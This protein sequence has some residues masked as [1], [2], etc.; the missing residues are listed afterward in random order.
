MKSEHNVLSS[1]SMYIRDGYN[2]VPIVPKQ[3]RPRKKNWPEL[4]IK[5]SEIPEHFNESDNIGIVLGH[6]LVDIDLDCKEAISIASRY[7]PKTERVHG[8]KSKPASHFWFRT[9]PTMK[10]EKFSDP[11]D[12][13]SL[14]E[15]RSS[16]GQQTV[17]P[18]SI[19]KSGERIRWKKEGDPSLVA[20]GKLRTAA[21]RIAAVALIAKRW[22]EQS[23]NNIVL[24]LSGAL[25]HAGWKREKVIKLVE[26]IAFAAKDE[27][28]E[29]RVAAV[30]ATWKKLKAGKPVTGTPSLVVELGE[31]TV[32]SL[33]SW[34][35]IG[36]DKSV[37]Q[38]TKSDWR[39]V[40]HSVED[41]ENAPPTSFSIEGFL[42]DYV[43]TVVAGLS[44]DG[45]TLILHSIMKALLSRH[46]H[47]KLWNHFKVL[48]I[49]PRVLYLTPESAITPVMDRLRRF[50]LYRYVKN[51]QLLVRTLSKGPTPKLSD[52]KIL[53]A[54]KG[55]HV[56]LDPTVRFEEGDEN[57]AFDNQRLANAIF[58]LL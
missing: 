26:A 24:P 51:G 28:S 30:E 56:F 13:K 44:G 39:D 16:T 32:N 52:P 53:A 21:K 12:G 33:C 4:R 19:H 31:K 48:E 11:E 47:K 50:D 22:K 27:E 10:S 58:T 54:A 49:A 20:R 18:P 23:R 3:K 1:A 42:Q 9:K 35:G 25:L 14:V 57:E 8:R 46:K 29:K 7:L 55:A 17:V 6:G 15:I 40:F 2:V 37:D 43:A 5:K 45:K 36:K 41:F 34:L 38:L